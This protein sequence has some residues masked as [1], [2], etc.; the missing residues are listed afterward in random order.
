MNRLF[1]PVGRVAALAATFALASALHADQLIP[2]WQIAPMPD[3]GR[4]YVETGNLLRGLGYDPVG[5]YVLLAPRLGA[6]KIVLLDAATGLDGSEDPSLGAPRALLNQDANGDTIVAGG[7]FALNLVGAGTDGAVYACNLATS[8]TQPVRIYRW[9]KADV[10]EPVTLAYGGTVASEL[11]LV[12]GTA[13]DVRFGDALAVRGGGT[14]TEI[15]LGS[16]TGRY[17]LVFRTTDGSTFTPTAYTTDL[18]SGTAGLGLAWGKGN[19]VFTKVN[20]SALRRLELVEATKT[21]R[22]L[23][24]YP[25]AIVP[26]T[27][28][29][30][31]TDAAANRLAAI[32]ISAHNVRVFDITD[33]A[34]PVQS[35]SALR[36]PA[37]G[38][39]PNG[40]GAAAFSSDTL[41]ALETN[42]GLLAA[43]I[44]PEVTAPSIATQ[45]AG[46][47]P[48]AGTSFTLSVAAQGTPPLAY[49]WFFGE[50]PVSGGST[51]SLA[52]PA[53]TQDKAGSYSVVVSNAAGSVT[54]N[55][56]NVTVRVPFN[57]P[58]LTPAWRILPGERA[59]L[60]TDSTQRGVAFNPV[61]GNVLYVAR[62]GGNQIVVLDGATGVE[63]HQLRTTDADGINVV[64]GGTLAIN[65]IGIAAD[66]AVY[67]P[68]L[69]IPSAGAG[70]ILRVYRWDSDAPDVGPTV[71]EVADLPVDVR[72]GDTFA[73]RGAGDS[74][75][76]LFGS[77]ASNS[78]AIA[79]VSGGVNTATTVYTADGVPNS[80]F[81]LGIAF[82]PGNSVFGTTSGQPIVHVA[83]DPATGT[84]T[85]ARTY[86]AAQI[87][88]AVAHLGFDPAKGLLAGTAL[89]T[90]DNLLLYSLADIDNPALLDQELFPVDNANV[91]GTGSIAF[92]GNRVFVLDS[93]NGLHAYSINL[94][95]AVRTTASA[96]VSGANIVIRVADPGTYDI[97]SATNPAGPWTRVGSATTAQPFST[98]ATANAA[99]FRAVAR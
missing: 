14:S 89:E 47:S 8:A 94:N 86:P 88:T 39:N 90:P 57:T 52:L 44:K 22:T 67:V 34:A 31:A 80:A 81:G 11:G 76:L 7:T 9:S 51:A 74:T 61:S 15:L 6:P 55:P 46:G 66:G 98:P 27:A 78:F 99:L 32:D 92:G 56:V 82:G 83:Y 1:Q 60:N 19:T 45:P 20:T 71:L 85:L 24:T 59:T 77:R 18:A 37:A 79:K 23:T 84:A 96:S 69:V 40:T 65:M 50:A 64:T 16:R 35:G 13:N 62:S 58:V 53:I 70:A 3:G 91:N 36:F 48:Y 68:N 21:A 73:V 25:T 95:P 26:L 10:T 41:F 4:D 29:P 72:F 87:P 54:S 30:I 63:K 33:P 17:L 42:N 28:G 43:L 93:N 5:K 75:E 38:A 2:Q 12:V 49:Q 97:E